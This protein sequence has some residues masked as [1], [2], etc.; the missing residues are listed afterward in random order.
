[1]FN[2]NSFMVAFQR[3]AL[4]IQGHKRFNVINDFSKMAQMFFSD[5]LLGIIF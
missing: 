5:Q 1:M 3:A 2:E 4:L